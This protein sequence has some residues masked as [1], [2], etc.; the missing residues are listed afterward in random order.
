MAVNTRAIRR[1]GVNELGVGVIDNVK[2]VK[3]ANEPAGKAG[4]SN[5]A[6]QQSI[7]VVSGAAKRRT[8]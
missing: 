4:K 7:G 1:Q 3:L 8:E 6:I 5:K 2:D